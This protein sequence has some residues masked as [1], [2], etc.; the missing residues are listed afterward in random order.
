[1]FEVASLEIHDIVCLHVCVVTIA[2]GEHATSICGAVQQVSIY[3]DSSD[4]SSSLLLEC[5]SFHQHRREEASL[6]WQTFI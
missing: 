6:V 5:G 4:R 2:S 1:M 3:L